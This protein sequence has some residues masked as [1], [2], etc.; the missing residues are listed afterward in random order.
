[1]EDFLSDLERPTAVDT[2]V[3]FIEDSLEDRS[4]ESELGNIHIGQSP[5]RIPGA[6]G[7][8]QYTAPAERAVPLY[9]R[10]AGE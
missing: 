10:R 2:M 7:G 9:L 8:Q 4:S 1:M 3:K 6:M 5:V